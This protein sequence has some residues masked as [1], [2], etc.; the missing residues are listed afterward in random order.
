MK[1]K[2]LAKNGIFNVVY[3]VAN[4]FFSLI[5]SMYISRVIQADGMGRVSYAQNIASYFISFA[6]L[7]IPTYGIR[8]IAKVRNNQEKTNKV[9]TELWFINLITTVFATVAY[10]SMV[11]FIPR[12]RSDY[13]LFFVFTLQIFMNLINTDWFYQGIEDYVYIAIRSIAVKIVSILAIFVFVKTR[14]DY[15]VYALIS[16]LAITANYLFN[17]IH[18]RKFVKLCFVGIE[19]KKH[20]TPLFVLGLS[21]FFSTLY[22]KVGVTM[23]G[24]L[25]SDTSIGLYTSSYKITEL[26]IGICAAISVVFLPRL[27]YYY[28]QDKAEFNKLVSYGIEVLSFLAF[29]MMVGVFLLAPLGISIMYGNGFLGAASTLRIFSLLV[30]IRSFGDLLC[31]QLIIATGNEKKRLPAYF[32]A[33]IA[34]IVL[35]YYLIPIFN[36]NGAALASVISELI[37]NGMQLYAISRIVKIGIPKKAIFDG[38]AASLVMGCS[39][40]LALNCSVNIIVQTIIAVVIGIITY[41]ITNRFLKNK[42]YV[43]VINFTKRRLKHG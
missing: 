37:V 40:L 7:G 29:P 43:S 14:D 3:Q 35:N 15:I 22:S 34:N 28:S 6:A 16:V 33:A 38:L 18:A 2:S 11:L 1:G 10:I 24:T 36:Q 30:I 32:I 27:S 5:I 13:M 20:I 31:Y 42:I 8:E 41:I 4:I 17:I 21:I 25:S 26:L 9:F 12:F 23:L 19:I 39:I